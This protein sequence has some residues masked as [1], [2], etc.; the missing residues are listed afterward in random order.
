MKEIYQ[1]VDVTAPAPETE[2][3]RQHYFIAKNAQMIRRE[4][5]LAGHTLTACVKTFGCQ[6]NERDLKNSGES[7]RRWDVFSPWMRKRIW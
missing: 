1:D 2:P 6:M 4:S 3:M 5:E 7:L